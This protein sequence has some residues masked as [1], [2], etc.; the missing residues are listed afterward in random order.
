MKNQV[1][2][3]ASAE[4]ITEVRAALIIPVVITIMCSTFDMLFHVKLGMVHFHGLSEWVYW[5]FGTLIS[6]FFPSFFASAV[7]LIWQYYFTEGWAGIKEGKGISL[8]ISTFI[9]FCF[10]IIYLLF[11]DSFF[12]YIFTALNILYVKFV[13]SKCVDE[14]ILSCRIINKPS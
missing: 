10:Y 5:I 3:N 4:N 8:G 9:Y 12:V 6:Y 2:N 13:L 7:S 1:K 14:K 11:S